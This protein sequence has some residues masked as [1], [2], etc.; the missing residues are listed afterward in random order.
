[1][2]RNRCMFK[3]FFDD[4]NGYTELFSGKEKLKVNAEHSHK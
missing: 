4:R 3:V 2:Y 1:M